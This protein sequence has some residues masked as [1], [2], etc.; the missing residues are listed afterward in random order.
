MP[1]YIPDGYTENAFLRAVPHIHD[2]VRFA[3]RPML[4]EERA[5]F[6]ERGARLKAKEQTRRAAEVIEHHVHIWDIYDENEKIVP[7]T[8]DKILRLHPNLF[9]RLL[10]VVTG[11]EPW[12]EEPEQKAPQRTSATLGNDQKNS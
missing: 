5:D 9:N 2:D 11:T 7:L 1:S 3:F 4:P 8:A 6:I 10:W 12:D